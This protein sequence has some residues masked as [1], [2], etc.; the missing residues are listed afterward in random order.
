MDN[1]ITLA[2]KTSLILETIIILLC[3][4]YII[5]SSNKQYVIK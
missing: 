2:F 3:Y 5:I 1:N 4:Y